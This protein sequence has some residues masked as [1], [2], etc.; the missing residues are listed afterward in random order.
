MDT[1]N[2]FSLRTKH[3]AM[4]MM[5]VGVATSYKQPVFLQAK[6]ENGEHKISLVDN[7]LCEVLQQHE[8]IWMK[9]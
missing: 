3:V 6:Q 5:V 7:K 8:P 4:E 9:S 1:H 2:S